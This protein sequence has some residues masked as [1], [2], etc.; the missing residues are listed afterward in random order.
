MVGS[1]V[2]SCVQKICIVNLSCCFLLLQS[3]ILSPTPSP[4]SLLPFPFSNKDHLSYAFPATGSLLNT[5]TFDSFK[6]FDKK[7]LLE[8]LSK[9]V[10]YRVKYGNLTLK[11]R[12]K[13]LF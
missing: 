1:L 3:D 6:K 9:E 2:Y 4:P 5:N 11:K 7:I 13:F 10:K 12:E 8:M